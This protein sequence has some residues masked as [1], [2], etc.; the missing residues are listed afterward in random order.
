MKVRRLLEISFHLIIIQKKWKKEDLGW[1]SDM[2][3]MI[4][5]I[6]HKFRDELLLPQVPWRESFLKFYDIYYL[7]IL[8]SDHLF[9]LSNHLFLYYM[10]SVFDIIFH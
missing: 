7:K 1:E 8:S 3:F 9:P 2:I 10:N 5:Q 6:Y 4:A